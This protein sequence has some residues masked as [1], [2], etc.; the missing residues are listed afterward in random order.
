MLLYDFGIAFY[1]RDILIKV[2]F[3]AVNQ[4]IVRINHEVLFS[5]YLFKENILPICIR[6]LMNI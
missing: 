5:K 3:V 1:K 2:D 6:K 4:R